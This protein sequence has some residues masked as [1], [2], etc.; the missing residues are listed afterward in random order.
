VIT[1]V[2]NPKIAEALKLHKGAFRE[3]ERAFLVEGVQAL[4]EALSTPGGISTPSGSTICTRFRSAST[5][6][7]SSI[8]SVTALKPTHN[9]ENRDIA[10]P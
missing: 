3:R 10:M 2:R 8:V 9:P 5:V 4:G 7:V 6:R 1:S